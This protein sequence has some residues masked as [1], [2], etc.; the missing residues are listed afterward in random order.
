M[1]I[2]SRGRGFR[3]QRSGFRVKVAMA[4]LDVLDPE[5]RTL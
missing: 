1:A 2:V 5:P 3:V 4:G